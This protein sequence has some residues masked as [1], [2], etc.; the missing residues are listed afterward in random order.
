MFLFRK[1]DFFTP[2]QRDGIIAAIRDAEKQ[3]SGEIRIYVESRCRFIDPLDRAAEIFTGLKMDQTRE[4]NGVLIY[5]AMKDRQAAILGDTGI[6]QKVGSGFW[7]DEVSK[8]LQ[9]FSHDDYAEGIIQIITDIGQA[10]KSNF[11]YSRDTDKNELP[12]D[13]VFGK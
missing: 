12:D 1:K 7:S 5:L 8:M 9:Q 10:L 13:L 6:D 11:P 2:E 3:T 4:R